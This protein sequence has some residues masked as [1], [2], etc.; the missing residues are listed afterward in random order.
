MRPNK[1]IITDKQLKYVTTQPS[2]IL[3]KNWQPSKIPGTL[4]TNT[5]QC[6]DYFVPPCKRLTAAD[7]VTKQHLRA[8]SIKMFTWHTSDAQNT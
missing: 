5:G 3:G 1:V 4:L 7:A 2:E 6:F 8:F